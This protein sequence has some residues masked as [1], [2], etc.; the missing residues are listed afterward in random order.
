MHQGTDDEKVILDM[1]VSLLKLAFLF[2][3]MRSLFESMDKLEMWAEI[4]MPGT[5]TQHICQ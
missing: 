1:S 3:F 2:P 4:Q 5:H